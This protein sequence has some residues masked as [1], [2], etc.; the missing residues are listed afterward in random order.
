MPRVKRI[1]RQDKAAATRRRML[2]AAYELFCSVG[3]RATT[4]QDIAERANVAVQTLY[5]TFHTKDELL[6]AVHDRTVLGDEPTPPPRQQWY[7]DAV[8]EPDI[9]RAIR[10]LVDG[11]ATIFARVA[12]M[13]PVFHTV[14]SDP[15]GAVWR[16]A[17]ELRLDGMRVLFE[18]LQLKA[19]HRRG[20]TP[21]RAV[22]LLFVVL[23]PELYRSF[24]IGR[25]WTVTAWSDWVTTSLCRD[26]FDV[27]PLP[28]RARSR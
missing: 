16:H 15:A 22:D 28:R 10:I 13:L 17:E 27:E 23:G 3:Y 7:L 9:R 18:T 19:K 2:D 26:L 25:G 6:Q 21:E 5:F 4:M 8:A 12:P 20:L 24:V 11:V 14:S 1:S